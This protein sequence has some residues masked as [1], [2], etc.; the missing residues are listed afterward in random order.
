VLDD[1][2]EEGDCVLPAP[3]EN[4]VKRAATE[5]EIIN[6]LRGKNIVFIISI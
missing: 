3:G 1:G 2:C 6:I 5:M 4:E